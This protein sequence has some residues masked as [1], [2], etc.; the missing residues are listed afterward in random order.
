MTD[1]TPSNQPLPQQ[2]GTTN[3]GAPTPGKSTPPAG[4]PTGKTGS[5]PKD[6]QRK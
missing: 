2:T 6:E 5:V 1:K 4:S 3:K